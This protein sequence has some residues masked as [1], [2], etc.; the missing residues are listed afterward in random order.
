MLEIT[1]KTKVHDL[2]EAYPQLEE[3]LIGLNPKYRKLK[4]PIL[5]RTVAKIATLTQVA[6]IGGYGVAELVNRL[7]KEVG[8]PPLD[9]AEAEESSPQKTPLWISEEPAKIL[10]A[11]ALLEEEK[12]PLSETTR[13]LRALESGEILLIESDFLPAPLIDTFKEQG[14]EVYS[15]EESPGHFLT[16]IRKS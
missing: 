4:N 10:D 14:H 1:P 6:M 11:N 16:Y 5:R 12:N 3:F 7:R 9:A 2:L 13:A 15:A 8:Q